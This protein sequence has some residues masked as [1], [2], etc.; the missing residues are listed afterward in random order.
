M[1]ASGIPAPS[2]ARCRPP[3]DDVRAAPRPGSPIWRTSWA[4][5]TTRSRPTRAICASSS[6][7]STRDLGRAPALADL[8]GLDARQLSRLPGGAAPRQVR[9]PLAGAQPVGLRTFFRW[10]D[11]EDVASSRAILQVCCP[12]WGTA[13]PSR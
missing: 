4:A 7:G 8:A 3:D 5:P 9:E 12:R 13:S 1:R 2:T 10:L 11:T 6:P